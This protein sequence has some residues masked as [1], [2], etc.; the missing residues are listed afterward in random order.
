MLAHSEGIAE[1]AGLTMIA[2]SAGMPVPK[3]IRRTGK[4]RI[5]LGRGPAGLG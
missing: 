3:P 1:T 2:A 5:S 4:S